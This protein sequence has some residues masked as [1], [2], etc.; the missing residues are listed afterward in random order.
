[1]PS[2]AAAQGGAEAP[3]DSV[4]VIPGPGY[5]A[6]S[7]H[8]FFWGDHYR[9][10][11]TTAIRVPVLDL[12]RFA[13]GLTPISA[14]GGFQ[15]KSLWLRGTDGKIY[16]F[17]S[18][19]KNAGP[20]VPPV[21]R[22]TFV[23]DLFQDQMSTQYPYAPLVAEPLLHAA[24]VLQPESYL[25]V[26]PDEAG[27]GEFRPEFAGV[28]GILAER[29]DGND[30]DVAASLGVREV[31]DG[32]EV[33]ER[34]QADPSKRA[35]SRSY[36]TARLIDVL[37]GDWD[38]H[39]DQWRWADLAAETTPGWR[40]IPSDRDQ[41]FVRL[42]GL[43]LGVGRHRFPMLTS[44][45][46]AY[47][48]MSRFHYQARF[49]DRLILTELERPV[50]DSTAASLVARLSDEVIQAA[51]SKLPA[52]V[53]DQDGPF[54]ES[55]L[56]R[57]RD[58]L[59]RAASELYELLAREPYVHG[60][61]TPDV[62]EVT[63]TAGGVEIAIWEA[64][65]PSEPYFRRLFRADETKEI[66]LYLHA[67]NDRVVIRAPG[68]LPI[69]VNIIGGEGDDEFHFASEAGNIH[70]YDQ[71]GMNRV[72]GTAG[73]G[74]NSKRY[75]ETPMVPESGTRAPPRHWGRFSYPMATMGYDPDIGLVVGGSYTW[76]DYGFRKDPYASRLAISG[77]VSSKAKGQ[78][79]VEAD[80][81]FENSPLFVGL[82]AIGSSL[83]ILRLYGVGNDTELIGGAS[84]DF[85]EAE[86]TRIEGVATLR[87]DYGRILDVGIGVTGGF[88]N[89]KDDPNTLL[90]QNPDTYGAG[91]FGF[92]GAVVRLDLITR[93]PGFL[94]QKA[95]QPRAWFRLRGRG[96]PA[97]IDVVESYAWLDLAGAA[98]LPVGFR[99][100]EVGF[101]AGGRK[102]WGDAPWFQL[103]FIGG[104][105][106]LRG[107]PVQRFAGDA[108]LYGSTELRLDLFDYRLVFP[109]TFG[110]LGLAD[111]GRVWLDGASPGGWHTAVGGGIWLALRGT[112]S[113]LSAA[114]A[115]S[116]EDDG[117]YINV[118]FPF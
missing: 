71:H 106:S 82:D 101:R 89:T 95:T 110:I 17:R 20:L 88:S 35:H 114:Y 90:G 100:W 42:D 37:V 19:Y 87:S 15:T 74:I 75:T 83:E 8:R 32:F 25:Y 98:S 97:L 21:L 5:A 105:N 94:V 63:A 28:L 116:D 96:Y 109:T 9:D 39:A 47:D 107:W 58:A 108:S 2:Q 16:A 76:F 22:N 78:L 51:V 73:V 29:P 54:L 30:S 45:R 112:R 18:V 55:A 72:S 44:F 10:T 84:T 52:E 1:M 79:G 36:L 41:A 66:R 59:P 14:G 60:S 117:L 113:I 65:G 24:G 3:A 91:Q 115:K 11:W 64:S 111:A 27:L 34:V 57:R 77:A 102:I 68:K 6:G 70:L 118:G 85:Y 86:N 103:A 43:L 93:K 38:R 81:R 80:F 99:R 67:G 40:P 50:W 69:R 48:D 13:G 92:V 104:D 46:D 23:E 61:D 56:K 26:L 62:A 12:Q 7:S 31:I 53:R 49:T 33:V 4:S